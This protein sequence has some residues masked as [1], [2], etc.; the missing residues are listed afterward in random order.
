M[1]DALPGEVRAGDA[2]RQDHPADLIARLQ[3]LKM[4]VANRTQL[5]AY[6]IEHGFSD[7]IAKWASTNLRPID[8]DTRS[9]LPPPLFGVSCKLMSRLLAEQWM[10]TWVCSLHVA[11]ASTQMHFLTFCGSQSTIHLHWAEHNCHCKM[12]LNTDLGACVRVLGLLL[13]AVC[14]GCATGS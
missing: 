1:L 13:R 4:P 9:A 8:G 2:Q 7:H 6:L 5:Q 3:Q 10:M 14:C 12:M 11:L